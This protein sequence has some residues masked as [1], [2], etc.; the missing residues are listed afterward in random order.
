M[1]RIRWSEGRW[2]PAYVKGG[3]MGIVDGRPVYAAGMTMPWRET[4]SAWGYDADRS[5]WFPAEPMPLGRCYTTGATARDG[6]LVIGGRKSQPGT[7]LTVLNDAWWLRVADGAWRW[8][9]LPRLSQPRAKAAVDSAGSLAVCIGGGDWERT[10]GGAFAA[11]SVTLAESLDLADPTAGWTNLG[12]PPFSPRAACAAAAANGRIYVFG[13]YNCRANDDGERSFDYYDDV[14]CYDP[15]TGAWSECP[16]LPVTLYGHTAVA[17]AERYVILMGGVV[18]L[19]LCGQTIA[20][21]TVKAD[22]RAGITGEYSD[23]AWVYDTETGETELL[24]ERMPH[25]LNDMCACIHGDT[26][27]VVGGENRDTTTSN[28]SNAVMIGTVEARDA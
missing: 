22:E 12:E 6:L 14:Y 26:I 18:R 17:H 28:T 9:E 20:Y 24:P 10:R 7:G 8:T 5:D 3:A 1:I 4:E 11:D 27:Y 21:H 16:P 23:L 13:G 2:F 15:A 25:G 19:P